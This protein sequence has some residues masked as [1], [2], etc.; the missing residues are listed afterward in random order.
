[1]DEMFKELSQRIKIYLSV[2]SDEDPY[3]HNKDLTSLPSLPISAIVSD[4]SFSK[5]Q[6]VMPAIST[7]SAKEI[8]IEKK[9]KTLL[10]QSYKIEIDGVLYEGWRVNGQ[11][12]LKTE[13][14]FVRAYIFVKQVT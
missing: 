7:T 11:M 3:E 6:W 2:V 10:E 14:N 13:G 8:L 12:Q 1:M 4:L 9:Y 5:V